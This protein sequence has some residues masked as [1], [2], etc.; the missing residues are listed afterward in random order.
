LH[1]FIDSLV[2]NPGQVL[3]EIADCAGGITSSQLKLLQSSSKAHGSHTDYTSAI[4]KTAD[5]Y[6]RKNNMTTADYEYAKI[7]LDEEL[8]SL[9]QYKHPSEL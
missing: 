9:F 2:F 4:R 5:K 6:A 1:I 3:R 7:H 8:M